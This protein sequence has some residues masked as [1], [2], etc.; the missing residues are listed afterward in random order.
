MDFAITTKLPLLVIERINDHE[1]YVRAS[2]LNTVQ[3]K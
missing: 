3:V 2:A 1:P